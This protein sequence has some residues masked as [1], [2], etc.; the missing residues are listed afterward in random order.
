MSAKKDRTGEISKN[1]QGLLMRIVKYHNNKNCE[2]EFVQTHERRSGV[3]YINFKRGKV[4]ANLKD[5]PLH[6]D[7][8]YKKAKFFIVGIG[9][10]LIGAI[11]ALIWLIAR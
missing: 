3:S 11:A 1:K 4:A 7:C 9:T 6:K 8:S 5:F 10:V 2:I